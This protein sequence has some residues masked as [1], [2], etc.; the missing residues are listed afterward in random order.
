MKKEENA[1]KRKEKGSPFAYAAYIIAAVVMIAL[2]CGL[3]WMIW[4]AFNNIDGHRLFITIRGLVTGVVILIGLVIF[5]IRFIVSIPDSAR[6]VK[7]IQKERS[8]RYDAFL[9][10]YFANDKE[11]R[12]A[13]LH[14]LWL[15]E[16]KSY[17]SAD[18]ACDKLLQKC[19]VPE[20]QA[21]IY[22]CKMICREEMGYAKEAITYGEKAISLRKSYTPVLLKT[23]QLCVK[24]NKMTTAEPYLLE[25]QE[26]GIQDARVSM[27]LYQVYAAHN[28]HEEALAAAMRC[29][30]LAPGSVEASA[31]VCRA[32]FKCEKND[33]VNSRLQKCAS[34]R[35]EGYAALRKEVRGY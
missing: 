24:L 7:H 2:I 4:Q 27:M 34:E 17:T 31:C 28:R 12:D 25:L 30:E 21:A 3:A 26:A 23:A 19:V 11:I 18:T 9:G 15:M 6:E 16:E 8:E 32:A 1:E 35:Y 22:Y 33:L 14:I 20:E 10:N 29:E 5:T 13:M